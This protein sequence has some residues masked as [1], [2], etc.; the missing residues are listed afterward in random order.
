MKLTAQ[1]V[2]KTLRDELA[3]FDAELR[4]RY[5]CLTCGL[6]TC[7]I[8]VLGQA[9]GLCKCPIGVKHEYLVPDGVPD[10]A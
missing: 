1:D 10:A 3:T 2:L 4:A 5:V 9:S 8:E 7:G 6:P